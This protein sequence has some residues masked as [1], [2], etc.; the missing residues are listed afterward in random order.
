MI[1]IAKEPSDLGSPFE[2]CCLCGSKSLYWSTEKDVPVCMLCAQ[3]YE[4]KDVPQKVDW[5]SGRYTFKK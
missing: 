5:V 4:E 3:K 1:K 2:C